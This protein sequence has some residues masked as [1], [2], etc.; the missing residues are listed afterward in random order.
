MKIPVYMISGFL[1]SGKTTI[2]L[3]MIE[4][5]KRKGLKAGIILNELGEKN[6]EEEYFE[7]Q[8]LK[9]LLNGCICCTIQ[10]DLKETLRSFV[11]EN[12]DLLLI[13][14]T[15]VANPLD[16]EDALISP[17]FIEVFDL[18]SMISIVDGSSF[19]EYQNIFASSKEIRQLLNEQISCAT[20]VIV[21]KMDLTKP[22]ALSKIDKK[23]NGILKRNVP[24]FKTSFGK[25]ETQ[26]LFDKRYVISNLNAHQKQSH[27]EHQHNHS[28]IRSV[29]IKDVPTMNR[30]LL[31]QWV[32]QLPKEVLRGKGI[33]EFTETP[34]L[35]LIQFSSGKL[36]LERV[37]GRGMLPVIILI[38]DALNE[39]KL[40]QSFHELI[41]ANFE[42]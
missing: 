7:G 17:E 31:N 9:Q 16:I 6:V 19:L 5:C 40:N 26:Q 22:A 34:G 33:V 29:Q 8:Y 37:K 35:F 10:D 41:A 39:E 23:I 42:M 20:M 3:N 15:G 2:L 30:I 12:I 11:G 27:K 25:L 24:V 13:E 28:M 18:S 32:E 4:E 21:N 38:G 1:G 14:G 36:R